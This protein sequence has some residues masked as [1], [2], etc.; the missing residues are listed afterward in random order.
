M[1]KETATLATQGDLLV[2]LTFRNIPASLLTEFVENI[3]KP[4]YN[5]N[6]N[7][8][9]QDLLIK[10]L[11]EQEFVHSHITHVRKPMEV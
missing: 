9:I 1:K 10:A 6:L 5:G 2:D 7:A 4:Y 11:S 3:V 8:A